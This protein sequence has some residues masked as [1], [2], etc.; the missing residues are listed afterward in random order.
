MARSEHI[1]VLGAGAWG[2]ALAIHLARNQQLTLLWGRDASAIDLMRRQRSNERYLAGVEFPPSL[3]PEPELGAVVETCRRYVLAVPTQALRALL[4]QLKGALHADDVVV[5]V[6]KGLEL[7]TGLMPFEIALQELPTSVGQAMLAGPSFAREVAR[8]CPTAVTIA[9]PDKTCARRAGEWFHSHA[10]RVYTSDDLIG[11]SLG[12]ALKNVL[13]IAVG[14]SDGLGLGANSRSALITRG[15]S[16]IVRLADKA[17]ARRETLY[18]LSGLGDLV[19]TSTDDQSR[20]RSLGLALGRGESLQTALARIGQSVEGLYTAKVV[21]AVAG[22][23]GV[24]LPICEQVHRILY[25][26]V[27]PKQAMGELLARAP[28]TEE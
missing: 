26:D 14:I 8:A 5:W 24:E 7:D 4:Q 27:T 13:A 20:N 23:L 6:C 9:A 22:N 17:G 19:L 25:Q 11:V 18:G 28:R 15:L 1:A 16:E 3:S 21:S 2:T 10:F 12:G